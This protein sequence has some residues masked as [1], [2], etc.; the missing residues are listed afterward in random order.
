MLSFYLIYAVSFVWVL[1]TATT[2]TSNK[3]A[4]LRNKL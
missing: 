2:S 1:I 3:V 4:N